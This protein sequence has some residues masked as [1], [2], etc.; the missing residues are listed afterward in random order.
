MQ[1]MSTQVAWF[2]QSLGQ[3][4]KSCEAATHL[5][6]LTSSSSSEEWL[7]KVFSYCYCLSSL[8][9]SRRGDRNKYVEW[10]HANFDPMSTSYGDLVAWSKN[11]ARNYMKVQ[12]EDVL[13]SNLEQMAYLFS[14]SRMKIHQGPPLT[15]FP[16]SCMK[17]CLLYCSI[18]QITSIFPHSPALA[19]VA[20]ELPQTQVSTT[21][22]LARAGYTRWTKSK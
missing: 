2:D 3:L 15:E 19:L 9:I 7:F 1:G 8:P 13:C 20:L 16:R 14:R 11:G 17:E 12:E 21:P 4:I 18:R 22:F 6:P 5:S 10:L